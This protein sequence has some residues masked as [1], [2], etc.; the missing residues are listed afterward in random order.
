MWV[1]Y[2]TDPIASDRSKRRVKLPFLVAVRRPARFGA[3]SRLPGEGEA[4]MPG[5]I[6]I[7]DDYPPIRHLLRSCIEQSTDWQVCGEAEDGEAAVEKVKQL[8]PDVVI[9]DFQIPVMNGLE[10]ARRISQLA[11]NTA[12]VMFTMHNEEQLLN[13]ARAAGIKD[14][15]SKSDSVVNH[16]LASLRKLRS[17]Q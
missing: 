14:V 9:L 12:M 8:H 16:L 1:A 13:E 3:A 15:V 17:E 6:L 5:S 11:L 10:T 4:V 7:V 2:S